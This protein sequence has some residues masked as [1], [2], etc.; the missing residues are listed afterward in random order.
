MKAIIIISAIVGIISAVIACNVEA[1]RFLFTML[2]WTGLAVPFY[3]VVS[4]VVLG[5]SIADKEKEDC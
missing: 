3:A 4:R 5:M 2:A 1:N